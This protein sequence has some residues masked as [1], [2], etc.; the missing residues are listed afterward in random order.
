[1]RTHSPIVRTTRFLIALLQ[2][3]LLGAAG[4]A[5][6]RLEAEV[7]SVRPHVESGSV[8]CPER[9]HPAEC[10]VC[11]HLRTP[12][13]EV[14]PVAPLLFAREASSTAQAESGALLPLRAERTLLPRAPPTFA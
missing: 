11:N 10:A 13:D 14:P 8:P 7:L 1:M 9:G 3:W 4:I 2:L 5:D 12:L 6:A